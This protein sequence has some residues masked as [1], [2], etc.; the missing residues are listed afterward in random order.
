MAPG[1]LALVLSSA[2]LHVAWNAAARA[3]AG[4]LRYMWL[5]MVGGGLAGL[6]AAI[7]SLGGLQLQTVWPWLAATCLLHAFYFTTLAAAYRHSELAWAYSLSRALGVVATAALALALF[8]QQLGPLAWGGLLLV[9]AGSLVG[10]GSFG[11]PQALWR[12]AL[13]GFLIAGYTLVDS[14]AVRIAPPIAYV[15]LLYLGAGLLVSPLALRGSRAQGDARGLGFGVLSIAS[16][17][18]M[19][20]AYRLGPAAPLLALRQSA[21]LLAALAGY[22]FLREIP[23]RRL[24]LGT[25]LIVVGAVLFTLGPLG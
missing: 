16:Y 6:I 18:L 8:G 14:H 12:V 11:Q 9:V 20:L 3:Q 10:A 13:I 23:S 7:P 21:P 19:L 4:R 17:L 2:A 15:A 1:V 24:L 25:G 22:F 5:I